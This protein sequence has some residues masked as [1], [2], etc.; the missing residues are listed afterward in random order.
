MTTA[1][2]SKTLPGSGLG[3]LMESNAAKAIMTVA[4]VI[5]LDST[6]GERLLAKYYPLS[7]Q[8]SSVK[9]QQSFEALIYERT[10]RA[11]EGMLILIF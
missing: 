2:G 9:R 5:I 11:L 10:K 1:V 6:S 8:S 7:E 3:G 4:A